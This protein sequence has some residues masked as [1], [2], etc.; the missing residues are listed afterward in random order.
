[1]SS[2]SEQKIH[3]LSVQKYNS[4]RKCHVCGEEQP[5]GFSWVV[6][7]CVC[8]CD[9]KKRTCDKCPVGYHYC[10]EMKWCE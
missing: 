4:S 3:A 7:T 8:G 5:A 9:E 1:M 6:I 10:G 2:S